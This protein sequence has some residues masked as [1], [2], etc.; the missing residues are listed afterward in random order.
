MEEGRYLVVGTGLEMS[1]GGTSVLA[2]SQ[3][4]GATHGCCGDPCG[5]SGRWNQ[6]VHREAR[7]TEASEVDS[8]VYHYRHCCGR[9]VEG[10]GPRRSQLQTWLRAETA[11][12]RS[13]SPASLTTPFR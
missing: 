7:R 9:G 6:S 12:T 10:R 4:A 5:L 2:F 1:R 13:P 3:D 8:E 11:E